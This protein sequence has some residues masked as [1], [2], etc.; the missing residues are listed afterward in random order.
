MGVVQN[1]KGDRGLWGRGRRVGPDLG[2]D[3][4]GV[5][6]PEVGGLLDLVVLV[7]PLPHP[8]EVGEVPVHIQFVGGPGADLAVDG[9]EQK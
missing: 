1:G 8:R 5:Q 2:L 3:P 6:R 7:K 9:H 4:S